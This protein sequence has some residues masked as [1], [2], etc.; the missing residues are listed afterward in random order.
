MNSFTVTSDGVDAVA[1]PVDRVRLAAHVGPAVEDLAD[2]VGVLAF[3]RRDHAQKF[4][5]PV[6]RGEQVKLAGR[7]GRFPSPARP[8]P[9]Q[10][11]DL[12]AGAAPPVPEVVAVLRV[13]ASV[14]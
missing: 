3:D 10:P 5:G 4:G 12:S 7:S 9:S 13:D 1:D 2:V 6:I 11:V 14:S 8:Y